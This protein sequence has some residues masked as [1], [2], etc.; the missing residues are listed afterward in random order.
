MEEEQRRVA[1]VAEEHKKKLTIRNDMK[2]KNCKLIIV[3]VRLE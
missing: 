2:L 1:E 3:C